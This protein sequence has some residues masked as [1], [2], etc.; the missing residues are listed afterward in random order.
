LQVRHDR[1]KN[2]NTCR[3]AEACPAQAFVRV[4]EESPYLLKEKL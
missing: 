1:C 4:P 2:C 3:I